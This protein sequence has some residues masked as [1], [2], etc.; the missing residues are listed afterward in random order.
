[1]AAVLDKDSDGE[2]RTELPQV[3]QKDCKHL[4]V[5]RASGVCRSCGFQVPQYGSVFDTGTV[6]T[7]IKVVYVDESVQPHNKNKTTAPAPVIKVEI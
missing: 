4:K 7:F 2:E 1:M 5:K 3:P 6:Q